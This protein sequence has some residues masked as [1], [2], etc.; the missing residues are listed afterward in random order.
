MQRFEY[1]FARVNELAVQADQDAKTGQR[2]VK[3]VLVHDEP[4]KPTPFACRLL[5]SAD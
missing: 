3:A 2:K 1:K 4:F 5:L